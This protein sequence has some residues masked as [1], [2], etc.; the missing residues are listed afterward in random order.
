ML[1]C[2]SNS[3]LWKIVLPL[4]NNRVTER[5]VR[6]KEKKDVLGAYNERGCGVD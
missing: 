4:P 5:P 2:I 1:H 3:N 6:A